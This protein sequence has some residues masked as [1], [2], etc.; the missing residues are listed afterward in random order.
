MFYELFNY[1]GAKTNK[2]IRTW[3]KAMNLT[4]G[5]QRTVIRL[6]N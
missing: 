1:N 3:F 6:S 5:T 2:K 4:Y